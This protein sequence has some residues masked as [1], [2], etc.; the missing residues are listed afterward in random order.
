MGHAWRIGSCNAGVRGDG[1]EGFSEAAGDT[2]DDSVEFDLFRGTEIDSD[3]FDLSRR[4]T[5]L[6]ESFRECIDDM[7]ALAVNGRRWDSLAN[8]LFHPS[9]TS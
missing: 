4:G 9:D 2:I 1:I 6:R 3:E 5:P 8:A 7:D